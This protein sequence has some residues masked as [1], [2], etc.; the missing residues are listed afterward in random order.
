M[1]TRDIHVEPRSRT[2]LTSILTLRPARGAVLPSIG[3]VAGLLCAG[4]GLFHRAPPERST[5]PPGYA[6]LVNQ[7]G[8]LASD[9]MS[10][11]TA[12]LAKPFA[13]VT[14]AERAR[15]LH[16]MIDE[17][18]LVQRAV[19]LDL[20]E[21]TTEVREAMTAG[22]GAQVAAPLL[23]EEPTDEQLRA[24]Y[25][26][27]RSKYTA[28]GSMQVRD[29][30]LH[31]GG[32]ENADQS[33]AQAR[34]DVTEAVYQLRSGASV[35]YVMEHFGLTDSGHTLNGSEP[36]FAAKLHL[37]D[38]LYAVAAKLNE[39]EVS[40]PVSDK[41]GMHV[42][43]MERRRPPTTADFTAA[44]SAVYA[45]YREDVSKAAERNNVRILRSQAQIILAPGESE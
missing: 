44:R 10:Q 2:R 14:P 35:D 1:A 30:V 27:H 3:I 18:L 36:D 11:A 33:E 34:I 41:D 43:V 4:F 38:L 15:V 40:D 5:V 9:L 23:A 45:D 26:A 13:E 8:I 22:V 19:A 39:G 25:D 31:I 21:T 37:G 16:E 6:A 20:P 12:E 29:L 28:E 24:Y 42:L 7:K 32:Y 17:E